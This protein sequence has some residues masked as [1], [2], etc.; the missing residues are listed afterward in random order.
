M[1]SGSAAEVTERLLGFARSGFTS[2]NLM[3][4]GDF[5]DQAERLAL[6]VL[7]ALRA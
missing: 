4:V 5:R 3:P 7:P 1:V 2:M 6:T